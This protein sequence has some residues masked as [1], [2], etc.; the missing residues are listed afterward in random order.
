MPEE[1]FGEMREL[2]YRKIGSERCLFALFPDNTNTDVCSLDHAD[3]VSAVPDA[4]HSFLGES[5]NEA[6]NIGLLCRR[7]PTGDYSREFRGNFD[8]LILEQV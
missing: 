3:V 7:T 6:S 2:G 8:E 4:A 5:A 1:K